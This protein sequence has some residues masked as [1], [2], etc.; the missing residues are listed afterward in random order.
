MKP[1]IDV[2]AHICNAMDLPAITLPAWSNRDPDTG[3]PPGV[4]LACAAG[5]EAALLEA[6]AALEPALQAA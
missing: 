1:V 2:H 4:M 3:L 5:A 6:A